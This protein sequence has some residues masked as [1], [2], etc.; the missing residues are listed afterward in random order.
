MS[1]ALSLCAFS[2]CSS[3]DDDTTSTGAHGGTGARGGSSGKGGA[4]GGTGG[5]SLGGEGGENAQGGT[6]SGKGGRGGNAGTSGKSGS[7]NAG[8]AGVSENAGEAGTG[9][10]TGGTGGS[11][12]GTGGSATAATGGQAGEGGEPGQIIDPTV[13]DG[14][15]VFRYDTFGDDVFWTETLRIN[16]A[17]QAALDPTTALGLGF[18]VDADAVPADVLENADLTAPAT[19]VALIGL[20]AVVGVKGTVDAQGNLTRVGITCALCHSSVDD[21]V[22]PGI[23]VRIDGQANRDLDPGAI[24]ALSPGLAG[25]QAA[26]DVLNSW[27]PG[28]YDP[29][30]NIDGINHPVV[31]PSIY[32]LANVPL[33]TYTGDGPVSYW[34]SY[35]AVTQMH[36]QGVFFDPRIDVAVIYD[37]DLVTPKLPSLYDYEVSLLKPTVP[38]SA[39]DADAAARGA[40]LFTG[41]AQC[42]TC[43]TGPTLTDAAVKLHAAAETGMDTITASRSATKL[44]RTTP[45]RG[46]LKNAPYFHDGSAPTLAAV[47]THYDTALSLGLTTEEQADLVEYLKS[48]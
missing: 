9:G 44:Y 47:V 42:S 14:K 18:K 26:L 19:T 8:N 33:E 15:Q 11:T 2:G 31:I 17:I 46:L 48:L 34:N 25:N 30:W 45:L 21:S 12:G 23:G 16:E 43:H 3:D 13:Y 36:G 24:I 40:A 20:D 10:S 6:S 27:G 7:G 38:A 39:F 29:R 28:Y 5:S 4:R 1:G 22:M 41:D 32:G 35:V 37:K